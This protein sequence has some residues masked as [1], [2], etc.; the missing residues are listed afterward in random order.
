MEA[1]PARGPEPAL[2][3]DD[4][5]SV[6][7]TNYNYSEFL[8]AAVG[9]VARQSHGA[10]ELIVADDASSDDSL[11]VLAHLQAL[12][13]KRFDRFDVT[14]VPA[15][16]GKLHVLNRVLPS[17]RGSATVLL[18]AD[19]VLHPAY[20]ERTLA[21]LM[22]V[23]EADPNI[24]LVY[25]DCRL[26][27]AAGV[28]LTTG[29]STSFDR[30]LLSTCSYIPTCATTIT[31]ALQS[32]LPF[33]DRI[34]VGSKHH[35]WRKVIGNGWDARHLAEPLFDYRMHDRNISGI[36]AKVLHELAAGSSNV[37]MLG[38]YWPVE[39]SA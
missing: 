35:M 36:G 21:C 33:D 20:L 24:G 12:Y 34:R 22:H 6:V 30:A 19:D 25:T 39:S 32:S 23:R 27:D 29:R 5:I 17:A 11:E 9:S 1:Y 26:I 14:T 15:N 10:I 37:P 8:P 16:G 4:L 13:A 31:T 7:L 2:S 3:A 28:G 18:D 38:G